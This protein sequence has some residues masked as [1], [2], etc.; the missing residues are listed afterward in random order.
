M[1]TLSDDIQKLAGYESF[2]NHLKIRSDLLQQSA[3]VQAKF[4]AYN[5]ELNKIDSGLTALHK[6][7][8]I[9]EYSDAL[10]LIASSEFSSSPEAK[11]ASSLQVLNPNDETAL[12]I[13]L[14]TTNALTWALIKKVALPHFIPE[15]V[16]PAEQKI[17]SELNHD[18]AVS[19]KH[20]RIRLWLDNDGSRSVEWITAGPL[21]IISGWTTI[22]A[23]APHESPDAAVFIAREYGSFDGTYKLSPTQ[24]VYR[25][26]QL[27]DLD[28]AASFYSVGLETLLAPGAKNYNASL[29]GVLDRVK[30]SREGSPI[31]RAYLFLRL[32]DLMEHQPDSWGL[33]F[34]PALQTHRARIQNLTGERLSS[35]DWFVTSKINDCA[36]KLERFFSSIKSIS[37]SRQATGLLALNSE[38]SK[39]GLRYA[40]FVT[41]DGKAAF[42]DESASGEIWGYTTKGKKPAFLGVKNGSV[43]TLTNEAM[44]FSP[45]FALP[46]SRKQLLAN[47]QVNPDEPSFAGMLPPLFGQ[48]PP[49]RQRP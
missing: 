49:T 11:A 40:G 43:V 48:E 28:E 14:D 34:S 38:V 20:Q 35:G 41:L 4:A 24:P 19:G 36:E 18:P 30:D 1:A 7:N 17:L 46:I 2:T 22:K 16:M 21:A 15:G 39:C 33:T 9:A 31:F 45:L 10:T 26:Q 47:A 5:R 8:T 6:A 3:M 42:F 25:V 27:G 44:P 13:L 37:Y 23:Y 32:V 29:L 12:R